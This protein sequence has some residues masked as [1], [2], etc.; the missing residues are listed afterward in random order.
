M[1]EVVVCK[2]QLPVPYHHLKFGKDGLMTIKPTLLADIITFRFN[3]RVQPKVGL[4]MELY[5]IVK[6]YD[7]K[8][9]PDVNVAY[10]TAVFRYIVFNPPIGSIWEGI[11]SQSNANGISIALSFFKDIFIPESNLPDGSVFDEKEGVWAWSAGG[12]PDID[13]PFVFAQGET[14]RFRV[15]EVRYPETGNILMKVIGSMDDRTSG[16]G[17]KSWWA[18]ADDDEEFE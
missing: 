3:D 5:D 11:I 15:C 7:C 14:V 18:D 12:D 13:T 6:A 9:Y 2:D 17:L 8:S 16:L 4:M 1:F 10:V